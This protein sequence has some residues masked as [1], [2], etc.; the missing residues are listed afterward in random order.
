[1]YVTLK[2]A[3]RARCR[4]SQQERMYLSVDSVESGV[5]RWVERGTITSLSYKPSRMRRS[6]ELP[7]VVPRESPY[8]DTLCWSVQ[9]ERTRLLG[10]IGQ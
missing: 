1:M 5:A 7:R 6:L 4:T 10:R 9:P 2:E 3:Q 8:I